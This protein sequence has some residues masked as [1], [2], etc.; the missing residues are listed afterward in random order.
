MGKAV[1]QLYRP[2]NRRLTPAIKKAE[3]FDYRILSREQVSRQAAQSILDLAKSGKGTVLTPGCN[4]P[5]RMYWALSKMAKEEGVDLS[6]LLKG[7]QGNFQMGMI[8][9]IEGQL[10][11]PYSFKYYFIKNFLKHFLPEDFRLPSD[12]AARRTA[13]QEIYQTFKNVYVPHLP[14]NTDLATKL[15]EE[16]QFNLWLGKHSPI[17]LIV[18]GIGPDGHIAF[19]GPGQELVPRALPARTVELWQGIRSWKWL[20]E[21]RETCACVKENCDISTRGAPQHALTISLNTF[22]TA[23]KIILMA[24]GRGKAEAIRELFYG[25][26]N[27]SNFTAH[28]LGQPLVRN[29]VTILLDEEAARELRKEAA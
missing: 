24:I 4:T 5:I 1:L 11:H 27:P 28:Y 9:G 23:K 21:S 15:A 20:D 13:I 17:D 18:C 16:G 26:Y 25:T 2:S 29:K 14:G 3:R 8:D 10:E 19:L 22:I 7:E 6:G 12:P